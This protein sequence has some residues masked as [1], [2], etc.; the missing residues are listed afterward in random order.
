[1]RNPQAPQISLVIAKEF[2]RVL[3]GHDHA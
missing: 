1:V 2:E 3:K